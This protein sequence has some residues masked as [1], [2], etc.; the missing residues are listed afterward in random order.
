MRATEN[1]LLGVAPV[2]GTHSQPPALG[3]RDERSFGLWPGREQGE[4]WGLGL[5]RHWCSPQH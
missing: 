5:S 4:L 2:C 1:A 3:S